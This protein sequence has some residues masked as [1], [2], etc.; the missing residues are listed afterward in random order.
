MKT[1]LV[2]TLTVILLLV[3]CRNYNSQEYINEENQA[4]NDLIPEMTNYNAMVKMNNYDTTI[5]K[6]YIIS[7][8]DTSVYEFYK[9]EGNN[10]GMNKEE[11]SFAP[12]K[13]GK[14]KERSLNFNFRCKGLKIELKDE[15][16]FKVNENE[17][18]Y[19]T[20]SRII[21]NKN[22]DIGYLSYSFYCG[23]DCFWAENIEIKKING[24]W[25]ISE[26]FSGGIA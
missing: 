20:V 3:S 8:L 4:I 17:F 6:L 5:L 12:L 15:N 11:K 2:C 7:C 1:K 21:F 14:I 18:G 19:L 13:N 24:K 26:R 16:L 25:K 9:P 23:M 10:I 22:F